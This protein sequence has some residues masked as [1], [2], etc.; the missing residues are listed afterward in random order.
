MIDAAN[1]RH[2]A[3]SVVVP[4]HRARGGAVLVL[5]L[6]G[7]RH[8]EDQYGAHNYHALPVV[9]ARGEGVWV[10]DVEDKRYLDMLAG[11]GA[12]NQGHRH[13][14]IMKALTD[15][16]ER[17]T[18]TARAFNNDVLGPLC[19]ELCELTGQECMLP[20]NTGAEAVETAIKLARKWAYQVKKVPENSAEIIV[21]S[22][23]FHGRTISVIS[24]ST[25]TTPI[26][27]CKS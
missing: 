23:N 6:C 27:Q 24:F 13:P 25:E 21:C 10:W 1:R 12:L 7:E 19:K 2:V 5:R 26:S 14:R 17:L 11:Y 18:L 15:Q 8:T 22:N 4:D 20:M 9:L 3:P 16:A